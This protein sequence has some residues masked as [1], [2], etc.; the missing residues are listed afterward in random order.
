MRDKEFLLWLAERL[1]HV[2]KE[3][4]NTDFVTNLICIANALPEKQTT[5][6][7]GRVIEDP[8]PK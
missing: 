8:T 1:E 6:N 2:Y 7:M 4:P 5:P 3:D